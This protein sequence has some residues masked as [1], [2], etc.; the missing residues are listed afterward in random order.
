MANMFDCLMEI[1]RSSSF[2]LLKVATVVAEGA[3]TLHHLLASG[4]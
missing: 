3:K 4:T 1:N 2:F